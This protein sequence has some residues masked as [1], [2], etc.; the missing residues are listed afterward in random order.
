MRFVTLPLVTLLI[1]L[2]A[3]IGFA[4]GDEGDQPTLLVY[5]S[6]KQLLSG[7]VTDGILIP[8]VESHLEHY[9]PEWSVMGVGTTNNEM[10]N[11]ELMPDGTAEHVHYWWVDPSSEGQNQVIDLLAALKPVATPEQGEKAAPVIDFEPEFPF[12]AL[13]IANPEDAVVYEVQNVE[14]LHEWLVATLGESGVTLAGLHI[15]GQ[16]GAVSTTVGYNLPKVGIDLSAAY[17][18]TDS[19]RFIDYAEPA[20]WTINGLY[21][22]DPA[23]QPVISTEGR[24]VHLH[25]YQDEAMVGGHIA[26]AAVE[27]VTVTVYPLENVIQTREE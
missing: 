6:V 11:G 13:A 18:N 16:F 26:K 12:I 20:V 22:S 19:F 1:F 24:P 25:G 8:E 27:S 7:D 5:S 2:T 21:S 17:M 14:N 23:L 10:R 9:A 4:Q 3:V 15:T